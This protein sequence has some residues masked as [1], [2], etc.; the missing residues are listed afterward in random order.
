[1]IKLK[2]I[3]L[4]EEMSSSDKRDMKSS[5]RNIDFHVGYIDKEIKKLVKILNK[6][7]LRKSSRELEVSF[8]KKVLE[9]QKDV[10]NISAQ[11]LQEAFPPSSLGS[12]TYSNKE[13]MKFSIDSVNKAGKIIG[14]AQKRVVDIFT[15]DL[16]NKKY[17]RIDLS[18][19][20]FKGNIRDTSFSKREVLK[21]LF[22]DLKDRFVKYG[23]R[24]K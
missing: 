6:E 13:A 1:M 11:H 22:Y 9:F 4:K 21:T 7:G 5:S 24:K 14:Q 18:R 16:K 8:K 2:N 17:D 3:L 10:K 15:S 20:I 12:S 19:S 23:R